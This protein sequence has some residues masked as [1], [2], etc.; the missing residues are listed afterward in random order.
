MTTELAIL[1][2][3][4]SKDFDR[5]LALHREWGLKWLDLRDSIYGD[6]VGDLDED[7][8][9]RVR[10]AIDA[11]GLEVYC[12]S[13]TL[14]HEDLAKGEEHFRTHHIDRIA[15]MAP[16]VR[17]LRPKFFRLLAARLPEG[18]KGEPALAT[19][20]RDYK[21]VVPL[22]RE[23]VDRAAELG[24]P[25]TIENEARDCMLA[26]S[27]DMVDF[28]EALD[29]SDSVGF[30]WD[31]QNQWTCGSFPSIE[32]Y[33]RLKPLLQYVHVKGGQYSDPTTR[34]LAFKS[35]LEEA[36][37]PVAEIV[38]QVVDDGVSPVLCINP[39]KGKLKPEYDYDYGDVTRLD[40]EFLRR[41]IKGI[42]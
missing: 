4:A 15:A 35:S 38:Q 22:Y 20:E 39:S 36:S 11:A 2:G 41:E 23:A 8:A 27:R 25:V 34:E 16:A 3:M 37:W 29:R 26:T 10:D 18:P 28:F 7:K 12:L 32:D 9:L 21:W 19:F 17:I 1:N 40:I 6:T 13:T 42:A 33:R 30:T 31:I 5:S 24:A 14:L